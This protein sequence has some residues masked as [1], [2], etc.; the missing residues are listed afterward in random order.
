MTKQLAKKAG[1][2]SRPGGGGKAPTTDQLA[3]LPTRYD[4]RGVRTPFTTKALRFA[5]VIKDPKVRLKVSLPGLSG[6][7]GTYEM[8]FETMREVF[9]LSVHDRMLFDKLMVL[10]DFTPETVRSCARE[11]TLTGVGGVVLAREAAQAEAHEN[12]VRE[13]GQ[14]TLVYEAL[15]QVGGPDVQDMKMADLATPGGQK[16]A[17]QT[18]NRFA[19]TAGAANDSVIDSLEE[20]SRLKAPVG[21][22][23]AGC[24]GPLRDLISALGRMAAEIEEWSV[25][26]LADTRFM[27]TRVIN[28]A[29]ATHEHAT[30]WLR[31]IDRW[32]KDLGQVLTRWADAQ[33]EIRDGL[34]RL[35]WLLD[36]WDELIARWRH[37]MSIDRVKQREVLEEIAS[38]VPILPVEE[39]D[40]AEYEF[41][42]DIRVNQLLWANELRKLGSG[43]IDADMV[44]R[45]E[46]FRRQSA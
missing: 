36:G 17:R 44:D 5:R 39:L 21:L 14:L 22:T 7:L 13:I 38:F 1:T 11:V 26:E 46:R 34:A 35:W 9:D 24:A 3:Y 28:S 43:E 18:L 10:Y 15:K 27:A 2:G 6:G 37:A 33:K 16:T 20:W 32:D 40:P 41:W 29:N 12:K 25:T 31:K 45:L 23:I 8:P 4:L 19:A 42:V 30:R